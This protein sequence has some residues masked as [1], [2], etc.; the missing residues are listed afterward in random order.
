M[1][2]YEYV[3]KFRILVGKYVFITT[4]PIPLGEV[5]YFDKKI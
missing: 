3:L 1:Q 4:L 5:N 2:W